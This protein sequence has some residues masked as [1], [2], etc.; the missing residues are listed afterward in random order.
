MH[1]IF[2]QSNFVENIPLPEMM[3]NPEVW[4]CEVVIGLLARR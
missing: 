3:S 2:N 1:R 4:Q